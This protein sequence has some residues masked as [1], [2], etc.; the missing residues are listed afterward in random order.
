MNYLLSTVDVSIDKLPAISSRCE[1]WQTTCNQ[2]FMISIDN[3]PAANGA[4]F[5][6][7]FS[8]Q[9]QPMQQFYHSIQ[10]FIMHR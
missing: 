5:K 4:D 3:L 10:H 1:H 2:Q 6:Q 7:Y 9:P 8:G